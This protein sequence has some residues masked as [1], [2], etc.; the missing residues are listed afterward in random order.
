MQQFKILLVDD[1]LCIL[2]ALR[3]IFKPEGYNIFMAESARDAMEIIAKEDIDLIITDQN[4]PEVSG[5]ELLKTIRKLYPDI[6]RI[7]LTGLTD[8][9]VVKNAINTGE[10]Y[11]FFNK[12]WDD[13]ELLVSVRYA[14]KQRALENENAHLK[15]TVNKQDSLL[16]QLEKEYPGIMEKRVNEDGAIIIDE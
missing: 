7:M 13:Y 16:K 5:N 2:K 4:M 1:S 9:E 15:S 11:R 10:I 12:P 6:I 8:I 14:L 3:R